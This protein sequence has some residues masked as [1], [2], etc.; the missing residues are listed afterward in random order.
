MQ[1]I[2]NAGR[3]VEA[4]CP[5]GVGNI[6]VGFDLDP[7]ACVWALIAGERSLGDDPSRTLTTPS[8]RRMAQICRE[9]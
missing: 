2:K 1:D 5:A 8:S 4:F 3:T 6:G 9:R 7:T